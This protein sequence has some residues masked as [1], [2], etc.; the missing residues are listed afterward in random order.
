MRKYV[1]SRKMVDS[2][3]LQDIHL[4][5]MGLRIRLVIMANNNDTF[6]CSTAANSLYIGNTH[7]L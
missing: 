7:I 4:T 2:L 3:I 1:S 6:L 5:Y